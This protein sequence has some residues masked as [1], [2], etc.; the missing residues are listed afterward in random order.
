[1]LIHVD[2]PNDNCVAK[3]LLIETEYTT[4][5]ILKVLKCLMCAWEA[6]QL[7]KTKLVS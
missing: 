7:A 6:S 4:Q 5:G 3:S 1:M 2:C